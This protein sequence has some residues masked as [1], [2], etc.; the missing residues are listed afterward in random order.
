MQYS[1]YIYNIYMT[2]N[3]KP[4]EWTGSEVQYYKL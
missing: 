1:I 4:E 3:A 2:V